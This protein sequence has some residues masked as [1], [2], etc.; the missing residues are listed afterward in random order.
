MR[1]SEESLSFTTTVPVELDKEIEE[2]PPVLLRATVK[3]FHTLDE[4][5]VLCSDRDNRSARSC[6]NGYVT[7]QGSANVTTGR[8]VRGNE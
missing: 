6:W 2:S 3:T 7:G 5:V 1:R 8:G 4:C